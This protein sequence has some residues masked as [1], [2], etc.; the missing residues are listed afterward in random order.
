MFGAA[1]V[2]LFIA[3]SPLAFDGLA[4]SLVPTQASPTDAASD[5]TLSDEE[6][7]TGDTPDYVVGEMPCAQPR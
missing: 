5:E 2:A 6:R 4:A 3:L 1:C 7:T